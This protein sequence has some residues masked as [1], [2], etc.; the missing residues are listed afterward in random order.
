MFGVE[1]L[2]DRARGTNDDFQTILVQRRVAQGSAEGFGTR[3]SFLWSRVP[4]QHRCANGAQRAVVAGR[5]TA[6]DHGFSRFG[7]RRRVTERRPV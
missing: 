4:G 3:R 5:D 6:R 1:G 7:S 2:L